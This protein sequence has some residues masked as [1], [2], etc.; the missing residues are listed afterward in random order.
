MIYTAVLLNGDWEMDYCEKLY[1]GQEVPNFEGVQVSNAVPGYWE[2]MDEQ[3]QQTPFYS[4]IGINPEYNI[5]SFPIKY[6]AEDMTLPNFKGNFY[7]RKNVFI[8]EITEQMTLHFD[9]VQTA[10]SVWINGYYL[11]RH[12]GYSTPFDME[13]GE[14]VLQV[15]QNTIIL[16]V[17][18]ELLEGQNGQPVVGMLGRACN[19]YTGGVIGDIEIRGYTCPLRDV[20]IRI[21]EDCNQAMVSVGLQTDCACEWSL[22]DGGLLLQKGTC[23]SDFVLDTS[24]LQRWSPESPKLYTIVVACGDGTLSRTFGVRRLLAQGKELYLNGT[25]YY[26]RGT[27]EHGYFAETIHLP[28]DKEYCRKILSNIKKLGFNFVRTHTYVPSEEFMTVADE[29]GVLLHVESP[30]NTTVEEWRQIVHFCRRHPSVVIYCAGNELAIDEPFIAYLNQL[31]DVVHENS[32][33]LFSPQSALRGVEYGWNEEELGK[34]VIQKPIPHNPKRLEMLSQFSD[35]YSSYAKGHFSYRSPYG[36]VKEVASWGN[37][38]QKPRLSHEICIDGTYIN[39][40]MKERYDGTRVGDAGLFA[41]AEKHLEEKGLLEKAPMFF[42]NSC[43]WQRRIR[44]YCFEAIRRCKSISGYDFLGPIDTHNHIFGFDC[45]MMNEFYEIKPGETLENIRMYNSPT[46]LLTDLKKNVNYQEEDEL[47]FAVYTSHY[48][49]EDFKDVVLR[50]RLLI[51][52]KVIEHRQIQITSIVNG[53]V[54]RL[55]EFASVLPNVKKAEAMKLSVVL[56]GKGVFVENQWELYVFPKIQE[57]ESDNLLIVDS[58]KREEL[59]DALKDGKDVLLLG[60]E[61]F[62]SKETEF[63][64]ALAGRTGGNLATVIMTIR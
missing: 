12:E 51:D 62:V 58:M 18:N 23:E 28:R 60:A 34:D 63:R 54:S 38:Y 57:Q 27:C 61:P 9:G 49:G 37:L 45:G 64:I 56:E 4:R 36:E 33:A 47:R 8:E 44:K 30:S 52:E 15:G 21:S 20:D 7:Y 46:V 59:L 42:E 35:V 22:W 2:D 16:S 48:G 25:P 32:D 39:L 24:K 19:Q 43:E 50:V 11:G 5:Q 40:N 6:D 14:G 55:Y 17:S 29:L 31:A 13:I 53:K 10:V 1:L 26:L 3:F 41:S